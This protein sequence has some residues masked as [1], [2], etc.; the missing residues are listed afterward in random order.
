MKLVHPLQAGSVPGK[1]M[2]HV[3]DLFKAAKIAAR[4]DQKN[5]SG[6]ALLLDFAKA[7]DSL[8]RRV[9]LVALQYLGLPGA[10]VRVVRLLHA[11]ARCRFSVN[12]HLSHWLPVSC[13][14]RQGCPYHF[15]CLPSR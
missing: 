4:D 6:M 14:I 3:I 12:G 8:G 11:G 9:L 10:F 15:S 1:D 13:G 7:C 2:N 5:A